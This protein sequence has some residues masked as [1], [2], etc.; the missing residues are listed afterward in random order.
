MPASL[1]RGFATAVPPLPRRGAAEAALSKA[2]AAA[3]ASAAGSPSEREKP[4]GIKL[5][6][7]KIEAIRRELSSLVEQELQVRL[8]SEWSFGSGFLERYGYKWEESEDGEVTLTRDFNRQR[9]VIKFS[10]LETSQDHAQEEDREIRSEEELRAKSESNAAAKDEPA[11]GKPMAI[12]VTRLDPRGKP[13]GSTV[14]FYCQCGVDNSILIDGMGGDMEESWGITFDSLSAT[15][16][17][18]IIDYLCELEISGDVSKY[19]REYA[20]HFGDSNVS[21]L[22]RLQEFFG[23]APKIL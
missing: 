7:P 5:S 23:D 22:K 3:A 14:V 8:K 17:D 20:A 9:V 6:N 1:M 19:V 12:E 13:S 16:K 21:S 15:L 18:R 11:R 10:M 2:A 4:E